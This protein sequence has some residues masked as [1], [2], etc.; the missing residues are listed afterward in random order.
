M[1]AQLKLLN[2]NPVFPSSAAVSEICEAESRSGGAC[3]Y[4]TFL[5]V[6]ARGSGRGGGAGAASSWAWAG[7]WAVRL[8]S[9]IS[10]LLSPVR[11]P[12]SCTQ[13]G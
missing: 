6:R 10:T 2:N 13:G 12:D 11:G 7:A 1:V 9:T 8:S 3:C 4:L 5:E